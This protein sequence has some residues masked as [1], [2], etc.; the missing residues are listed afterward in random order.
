MEFK[1]V[2]RGVEVKDAE[3]GTISCVFATLGVMDS[4]RDVTLPGAFAEGEQ[5]AISAYGH[6]VWDG[7]PP[8]GRGTIHEVGDEA[9]FRGKFFMDMA[10]GR[11][12]FLAVKGMGDIQCWSYGFTVEE[13]EYGEFQGRDVKFLKKLRVFE[14]SPVLRGAGVGTRTT[15][16]KTDAAARIARNNVRMATLLGR[17]HHA[18]QEQARRELLDM[19]DGLRRNGVI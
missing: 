4:D 9:I 16:A 17:I 19:R 10:S 5:V 15:D 3:K 14:V 12:T 6:K 13:S 1:G 8:V 7:A 18:Q 2:A 11:E